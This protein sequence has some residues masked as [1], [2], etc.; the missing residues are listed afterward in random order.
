ME[1]FSIIILSLIAVI[2]LVANLY[3]FVYYSNPD[4]NSACSGVITKIIVIAA[5]NLSWI[6]L[7]MLPLDVTNSRGG[8]LGLHMDTAWIVIYIIIA[9]LMILVLP[10]ISAY[11]ESDEEWTLCEKIKYSMCNTFISIALVLTLIF[12]GFFFLSKAEIPIRKTYC[13]IANFQK[14]NVNTFKTTNCHTEDTNL[15]LTVS[16]PIFAIAIL[17]FLSWFVFICFGSIGLAALPLDCFY[18]YCTRPQIISKDDLEK[19]KKALISQVKDVKIVANQAKEYE[20]DDVNKKS[21]KLNLLQNYIL[22]YNYLLFS[23]I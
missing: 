14:S 12:I 19:K 8:G 6:Q 11:N 21:S 17:S 5:M 20:Y 9:T 10:L 13:P 2:L 16:F 4:D 15:I 3:L 7:L 18:T 1:V 23:T 22:E